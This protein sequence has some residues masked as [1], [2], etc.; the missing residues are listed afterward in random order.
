MRS[1]VREAIE[2][3]GALADVT[4]HDK[5]MQPMSLVN[6]IAF[7]ANRASFLTRYATV[8][9]MTLYMGS[10]NRFR[11]SGIAG[12]E[13]SSDILGNS[14]LSVIDLPSL[15]NKRSRLLVI[16]SVL[17][18]TW[19]RMQGAWD[20]A[21]GMN[22]DLDQRV[23]TFVVIDEAHNLAMSEP[24]DPLEKAVLEQLRTIAAEGR[25][26]GLFLILVSQRPDKLDS[27]ILSE[28]DNRALMRVGSQSVLNSCQQLL[29]LD[30]VPRRLL[31]RCLEFYK[32]RVLIIGQWAGNEPRIL[33]SA[34]RRTVE[35]GRSIRDDYW[36]LP[37]PG[38]AAASEQ[39][40]SQ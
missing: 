27:F 6:E 38:T 23:P 3:S 2:T 33:Y 28:C 36:A 26:Y 5:S 22:P 14:R 37:D 25:K 29:G 9:S 39:A 10:Y 40:S 34:A 8:E 13:E 17:A 12:R 1:D 11:L 32:G 30:D 16:N 20:R 21:L 24:R 15:S 19:Q 31:E 4:Y 35:G 18:E 7:V